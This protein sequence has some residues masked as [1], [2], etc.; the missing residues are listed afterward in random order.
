MFLLKMNMP[1]LKQ[2]GEKLGAMIEIRF[3]LNE[4]IYADVIQEIRAM[5]G[6]SSLSKTMPRILMEWF[7]L[8]N[9]QKV[10]DT[11]VEEWQNQDENDLA[12]SLSS[13]KFE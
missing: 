10:G 1:M 12:D 5:A 11:V 13:L 4:E 7:L 9:G 3:R 8:K 6:K 2:I